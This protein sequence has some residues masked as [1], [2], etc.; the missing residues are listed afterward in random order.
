MRKVGS[1]LLK[2]NELSRNVFF[3][4][5]TGI[6]VA[7]W[8]LLKKFILGYYFWQD[9]IRDG[10]ILHYIYIG[11]G[12]LNAWFVSEW[13]R[14]KSLFRMIMVG[15]TPLATVMSLRWFFQGFV[16]AKILLL[17]MVVCTVYILFQIICFVIKKKRIRIISV[18]V[19]NILAVLT[20]VSMIGM[21]GYCFTGMDLVSA[22]SSTLADAAVVSDDGRSWGSNQNILKQWKENIYTELSDEEKKD[23]FQETI[24]L[25]CQYWGIEPVKLEVETY[26]SETL[27]GYYVDK[28]YVISIRKEMFDMPR[29]EVL[30]TLLHETHHAYVHKA[31]QSVDWDDKN[32]E[33]N[34]ELRVYKDLQMYK[35][36]IE[37]Y[38]SADVD[39]DGYYNNPI[40]VAARE[41]AEEWTWR[42]LEYI[43]LL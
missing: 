25:E 28:Y 36:G 16:T 26:E 42:Y 32:I 13:C 30:N 39:P 8:F 5:M 40:E 23:L 35:Q 33:K 34:K 20:V 7:L 12:S 38:V 2:E 4:G 27:M 43:E 31:V 1:Y 21:A 37:N 24:N 11:V 18:G 3:F 17:F 10:V 9:E 29:D 19:N 14:N 41:Y 15:L 22:P 6:T